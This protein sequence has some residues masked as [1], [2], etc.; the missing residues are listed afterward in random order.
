MN[1]RQFSHF[2][3]VL[4]SASILKASQHLNIS[5]PALSKSIS[6][7][8]KMYG[9][10]LFKRFARGVQPT[11]FAL[12]IEP[13]AR[14]I[15]ND[16]D[17]T[18]DVLKALASGSSGRIAF[19]A[20]ASF[21]RISAEAMAA[22]GD[23]VPNVDFTVMTDHA[24]HLRQALL[25][26][27]IDFF[28]GMYNRLEEDDTVQVEPVFTDRF[29]GLCPS[30]HEFANRVVSA[31]KLQSKEWIV[32]ELEEA[33]RTAL[34]AYFVGRLG[35]KPR[36][37]IATNSDIILNHFVS[38]RQM[39]TIMPE[40]SIGIDDKATLSTFELDGFRFLRKVGIVRRA[41]SLST[42]LLDRFI[43]VLRNM[44]SK[45]GSGAPVKNA[46]LVQVGDEGAARSTT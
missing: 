19:G 46:S 14:R 21:V 3:A 40:A 31:R 17:T 13:H 24:D 10:S 2:I 12:T 7:L 33:G 20:G 44:V 30:Q 34:E 23:A 37:R 8:E 5:Q 4:E 11:A 32:P 25:G 41:N 29:V 35:K 15:L 1:I 9:V 22:F 42:P 16:F 28:I 43:G 38:V 36:F 45:L 18:R 6:A 27:R 26:N 39:L